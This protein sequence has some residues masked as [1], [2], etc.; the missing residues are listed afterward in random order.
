MLSTDELAN[1]MA[2]WLKQQDGITEV[3][4]VNGPPPF[5]APPESFVGQ[6]FIGFLNDG[7]PMSISVGVT[8]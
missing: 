3:E 6:A 7:V 4:V 8:E 2:I 5:D 1:R